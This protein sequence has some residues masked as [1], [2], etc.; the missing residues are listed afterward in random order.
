MIMDGITIFY[1]GKKSIFVS[2]EKGSC[3]FNERNKVGMLFSNII[4]KFRELCFNVFTFNFK[5][6][7]LAS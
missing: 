5:K 3:S 6:L 2:V 4:N 7:F 1:S